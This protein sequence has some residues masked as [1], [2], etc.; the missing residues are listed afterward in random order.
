[1]RYSAQGWYVSAVVAGIVATVCLGQ[2]IYFNSSD[3]YNSSC[4]IFLF[5]AVFLYGAA[6]I[7]FIRAREA[8]QEENENKK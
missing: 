2:A 7:A 4:G 8:E 1:M 3:R 6:V 5:G